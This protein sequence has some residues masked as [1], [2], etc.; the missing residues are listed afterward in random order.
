MKKLSKRL[1][2]F[3][4]HAQELGACEIVI[5]VKRH[6]PRMSVLRPDG[7][8]IN[9]TFARTPSDWRA[10]RNAVARLRRLYFDVGLPEVAS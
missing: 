7:I 2:K 6:H 4:D 8:W 1:R 5:E 9:Q 10:D 3:R